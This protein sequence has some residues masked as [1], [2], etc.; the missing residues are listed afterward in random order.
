MISSKRTHIDSEIFRLAWPN[1]ISNVSVPLLSSVDTALMGSLS[2]LHLG[3]V[4]LGSMIFNFFYWNFGFLRMGTTGMTAQAYGK[5]D[6]RAITL[7]LFRALLVAG[8]ISSI[9]LLFQ[10][11]IAD[12]GIWVM[13]SES[14]MYDLIYIYVTTRIWDAPATLGLYVLFGWLFGMQNARIPMFITIG[15]N[16]V[17]IFLSYTFIVEWGWGIQGVA[18]G[19]VFAQYLGFSATLIWILLKYRERLQWPGFESVL[20][21]QAF[22]RFFRVN[23]L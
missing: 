12:V 1:I 13:Q 7:H 23:Y 14:E 20:E 22:R 9:L 19:T 6:D 11:W 3:A 16:L 2:P 4:G 17:N 15:L 5:K 10:H 8:T 21:L 18:L